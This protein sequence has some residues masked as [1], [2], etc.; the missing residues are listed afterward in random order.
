MVTNATNLSRSGLR[1]WI[2]QRGTSVILSA[3]FIFLLI[4]FA[5]HPNINF[6]TW[7]SLFT[8]TSVRVFTLLALLSM[9]LHA[10]IGVWTISTDYF[11]ERLQ[12]KKAVWFR[13]SFQSFFALLLLVYLLWGIQVIWGL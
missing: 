6:H 2:I 1:D 12:Q 4:Y 5:V 11:T 9:V 7:S 13:L 10:W 3:Y 8:L